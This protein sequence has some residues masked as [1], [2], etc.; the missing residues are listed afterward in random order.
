M[1]LRGASAESVAALTEQLA[2]AVA[3]SPEAASTVAD[4][5]NAVAEAFRAEP[6]LRRFAADAAVPAEAKEGLVDQVFGSRLDATALDLV[7]SAVARRWTYGGDLADGVERLA[8]IASV[9]SAGQDGTGLTDELFDLS[10]LVGGAPEL[11]DALSDPLRSTADKAGLL[12]DILGGKVLPATLTLAKQALRGSYGTFTAALAVYR[13]LAADVHGEG[14]ATVRVATP[15]GE[16]QL[17][18]LTDAL[19]QQYGRPVHANVVVEPGLL[20]GVRV[21]IGDDVIDGT[22]LTRLDDAGRRLAG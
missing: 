4:S 9:Y 20:G 8:E 6:A 10:R 11:R 16:A 13:R 1:D 22:I 14:V 3:D 2:T 5:L 19:A 17:T 18:R 7:R 15:L 12:Q 21:E